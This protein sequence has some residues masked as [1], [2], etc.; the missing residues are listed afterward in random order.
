MSRS[1]A[2]VEAF[3]LGRRGYREV[4][5][6]QRALVEEILSGNRPSTLLLLEHPHVYT[7][8]RRGVEEH[9]LWGAAERARRGVEVVSCDRGGD[10]TYHGPGQLVGY[11]LFD[12]PALGSDIMLHLRAMERSLIAYLGEFGIGAEPGG[13]GL[14]GVWS[15]GGKVA[16]IGVKLNER[17]VTNHGFALNLCPDL[18]YFEGIVPCGLVGREVTSVER[19][20]GDSPGPET[21]AF[22]LAPHL[23]A[24]YGVEMSWRDPAVL[25]GLAAAAPP[26]PGVPTSLIVSSQFL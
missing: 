8:G 2:L 11:P 22:E 7:M 16:A 15:G 23:A 5:A 12:L 26:E 9:L 25:D 21:A 1:Q 14:T 19:L 17:R 3:W 20:T 24:A 13:K 6:L 18:E 4:W 10:V